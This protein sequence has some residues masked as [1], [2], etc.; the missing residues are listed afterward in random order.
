M[1]LNKGRVKQRTATNFSKYWKA[2]APL[3]VNELF[4]S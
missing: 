4:I 3:Y 1:D 2:I